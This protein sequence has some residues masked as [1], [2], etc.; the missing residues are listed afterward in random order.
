M[1]SFIPMIQ[2]IELYTNLAKVI[3]FDSPPEK[4][5]MS[6]EIKGVYKET[7][8]SS[9][10]YQ[11]QF[12]YNEQS[13]DLA[14]KYQS[15]ATM[16]KVDDFIKN[17]ALRGGVFDYYISSDELDHEQF[18]LETNS[19]KKERPLFE[20][21]GPEFEYNFKF[22]IVRTIDHVL[23]VEGAELGQNS[24]SET[25]F[26]L[27]N[28]QTSPANITG[29]NFAVGTVRAAFIYY[30]IYRK[31]T[32]VGA[33]ELREAGEMYVIYG[34]SSGT[35]ELTRTANGDAQ[36]TITV[37]NAGQFQYMTSNITGTASVSAIKFRASTIGVEA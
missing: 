12:N 35:W 4:D 20:G 37:T 28:N 9:G 31:T 26:N 15:S 6:E 5:P 10:N 7:V 21:S 8:S 25:Q 36:T 1:A 16:L 18:R 33:T 22:S 34:D 19:F 30:S 27:A 17:H 11:R 32:G 3:T 29:L 24:I 23:E 2:Y 13:Y 14:F